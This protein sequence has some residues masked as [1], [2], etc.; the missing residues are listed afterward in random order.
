[1]FGRLRLDT[2][3]VDETQRLVQANQNGPKSQAQ[4]IGTRVIYG[5]AGGSSR[6][7]LTNKNTTPTFLETALRP[8]G[9]PQH[10]SFHPDYRSLFRI[11]PRV[12]YSRESEPNYLIPFPRP[13]HRPPP[14]V[15]S[16][17][18]DLR[19]QRLQRL[20]LRLQSAQSFHS[21]SMPRTGSRT[22]TFSSRSKTVAS[23]CTRIS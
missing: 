4:E 23:S 19:V 15:T 6:R 2:S 7:G 1:M 17:M 8:L 3:E 5:R 18:E 10:R 9:L 13:P 21:D 11:L 16:R 14:L 12:C 22:G 20:R